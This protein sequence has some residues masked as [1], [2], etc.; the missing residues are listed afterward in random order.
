MS[1]AKILLDLRNER[2]L[3]QQQLA[4]SIGISQ[5]TIAKIEVNRNEATGSTLKKLSKFFNVSAD[6]L[7][8]L[9]EWEYQPQNS[10]PSEY[11]AEERNLVK[12]YRE[13]K[14]DLQSLLLDTIKIWQKQNTP[15][16]ASKK[17]A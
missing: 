16:E 4:D 1:L 7:L 9:D 6:Y 15:S 11:T 17:K 8:E 5:S 10:P 3:S 13:L 2:N 12:A 14:P